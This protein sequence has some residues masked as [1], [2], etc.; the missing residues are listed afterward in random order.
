MDFLSI[1]KRDYPQ[2]T[3]TNLYSLRN[4]WG[5][6]LGSTP[7]NSRIRDNYIKAGEELGITPNM[8]VVSSLVT[9]KTRSLSGVTP[10]AVMTKPYNCP[11]QCT[12]CPLEIGMPKSYLSDEPAAQRAKMMNFDPKLQIESRMAQLTATGHH[13]EKLELIVIG[14][15]FSAY[16]S[17]YKISFFK[18]MFDAVNGF[19]SK[20]LVSAQKANEKAKCRVV[21]LSIETRPDWI[22]E[23]EVKLLRYL[24]VTKLQLGVQA[25]NEQI[26]MNIKRGHSLDA[27]AKATQMCKDAGF[28]ICYHSMP[29]LPGSTPELDIEMTKI[30]YEDPRFKP[31][32]VK[33]YPCMVIPGTQLHRQWLSGE[34]KSYPDEVIKATLKEIAKLTPRW[35]RVDRFVRDIS[36]SWV[37]SGTKKTNLREEIE[38]ELQAEGHPCP[39]I[40]CREVKAGV[41]QGEPD[42]VEFCQKTQGGDDY[43]LSFEVGE[44]L[45]S[46]LRL[47]L[48]ENRTN[49]LFEELDDAA[50]IREVHTYGQTLKLKEKT[51]ATQHKGLGRRLIEKAEKI[52]KE[53]GYKK[54]A[55]ISAIGTKEYYRSVGFTDDGLYLSKSL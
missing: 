53:K 18:D 39:C 8:E 45:L 33:I 52:A 37:A 55:V 30:M 16:P 21:G 26:L 35:V 25:F 31:D 22:D 34:Y 47:R 29:N 36:K 1:I 12:Y 7:K 4:R 2:I 40:R 20:D 42:Y 41:V 27:V 3:P 9:K 11:G 13:L 6:E 51:H 32:F 48:P 43:L 50:I 28:K 19:V 44:Q 23:E 10:F 24:G 15:T 49:P 54:I 38:K 14:G 5:K 17:E 46:I